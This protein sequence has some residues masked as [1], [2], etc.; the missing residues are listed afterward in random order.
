[1]SLRLAIGWPRSATVSAIGVPAR[2]A[3]TGIEKSG[4]PVGEVCSIGERLLSAADG[5]VHHAGRGFGAGARGDSDLDSRTGGRLWG[6]VLDPGNN[7]RRRAG[8]NECGR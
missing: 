5:H 8:G 3:S 4:A 6:T 2:K 1:M 7:D